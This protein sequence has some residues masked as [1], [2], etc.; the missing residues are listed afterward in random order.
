MGK[1]YF[2]VIWTS[3]ALINS[4]TLNFGNE[5]EIMK[6]LDKFCE[7]LTELS[8]EEKEVVVQGYKVVESL[9]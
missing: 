7:N 1:H 3:Q 5:T 9:P 8:E 2:K 4:K 6:E